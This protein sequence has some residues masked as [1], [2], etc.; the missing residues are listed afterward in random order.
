MLKKYVKGNIDGRGKIM[1][2]DIEYANS[3]NNFNHFRKGNL[4]NIPYK[5][6][7]DEKKMVNGN[8]NMIMDLNYLLILIRA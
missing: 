4:I 2:T 3:N 5:D 1:D 7:I 8:S 6:S